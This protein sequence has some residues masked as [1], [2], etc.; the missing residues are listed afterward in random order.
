VFSSSRDAMRDGVVL[1]F[2]AGVV[3]R[4]ALLAPLESTVIVSDATTDVLRDR[5]AAGFADAARN[6]GS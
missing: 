2:C 1:D 3:I 6:S 5:A 4:D